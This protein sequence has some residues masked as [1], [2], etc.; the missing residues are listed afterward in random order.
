M[1]RCGRASR[2]DP[3]SPGSPYH[4]RQIPDIPQDDRIEKKF[5]GEKYYLSYDLT[6]DMQIVL[7]NGKRLTLGE[8]ERNLKA[9]SSK[10][11]QLAAL[12]TP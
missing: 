10:R 12:P 11:K 5:S 4:W 6:P 9:S 8:L 3:R 2:E 7:E 1:G